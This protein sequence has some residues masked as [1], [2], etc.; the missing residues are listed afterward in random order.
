L[1][2]QSVIPVAS[3]AVPVVPARSAQDA[4][5]SAVAL[6]AESEANTAAT[7]V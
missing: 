1:R 4:A 2:V 5:Q 6:V 7:V 3:A